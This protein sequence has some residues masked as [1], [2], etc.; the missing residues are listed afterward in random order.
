MLDVTEQL[1]R[2]GDAATR[3][4]TPIG[5]A[6]LSMPVPHSRRPGDRRRLLVGIAALCVVIVV[7]VGLLVVER[8]SDNTEIALKPRVAV[9]QVAWT[10]V[11][12]PPGA[13]AVASV[14]G[15]GAGLVAVG[16]VPTPMAGNVPAPSTAVIWFSGDGGQTWE[17]VLVAPPLP[18]QAHP[19][20]P[21]VLQTSFTK[22][23]WLDG[24]FVALG[25]RQQ[26]DD[27]G[28]LA[29]VW[30]SRDG[31]SWTMSDAA[32]F[33]PTTT[34]R[35]RALRSPL[36]G[37][38]VSDVTEWRGGLLVVGDLY[39]NNR[40]QCCGLSPTVWTSD[41]GAQWSRRVL[42]L[43]DGFDPYQTSVTTRGN[44]LVALGRMGKW[45]ATQWTSTDLRTWHASTIADQ[46][47]ATIAMT[48]RGYVA[49]G[50]VLLPGP[51]SGPK[52]RARP[53]I[54]W[55][56]GADSW[57]QVLQLAPGRSENRSFGAVATIEGLSVVTGPATDASRRSNKLYVSADGRTWGAVP[58]P[59]P[60]SALHFVVGS[61]SQGIFVSGG[62]AL[63]VARLTGR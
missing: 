28:P 9:P 30:V 41:D 13:Q 58:P 48:G 49:A 56:R 38:T 25:A 3:H 2:Y 1:R 12:M 8:G 40:R 42:D 27:S 15:N 10:Q 63:W 4:A 50:S 32:P 26:P 33:Q 37:S 31:R 39:T 17:I 16:G 24:A 5:A 44:T 46:G 54:W 19:S 53:T 36:V 14:A 6:E 34:K 51:M 57:K 22:V 18:D 59:D 21:P 52:A 43:G 7:V 61:E 47:Y 23:R 20:G 60:S 29:T 62:N 11:A 55:S 45:P 35:A